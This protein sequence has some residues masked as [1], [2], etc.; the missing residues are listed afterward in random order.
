MTSRPAPPRTAGLALALALISVAVAHAGPRLPAPTDTAALEFFGVRAGARLAELAARVRPRGG[1]L[2]CKQATADPRVTEC[3]GTLK[4][5]RL[6]GRVELWASAVDS[7]AG[8]ITL[9]G[10]VA[11]EQLA[12]WRRDVERR[13]GRVDARSQGNQWMMQWVRQG[14]MLR[15]TWRVDG[16]RKTA[17]VS[18]VDGHILDRWGRGRNHS[19]NKTR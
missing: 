9:S 1:Q 3:R 5:P 4:D 2:R 12:Y 15:L 7:A 18:L 10:P 8:I 13:Y 14:R 17:S 19:D 16:S 11:T 6:G